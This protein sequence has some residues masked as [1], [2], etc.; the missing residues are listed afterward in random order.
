M[1]EIL[2]NRATVIMQIVSN[3]FGIQLEQLKTERKRLYVDARHLACRLMYE[4]CFRVEDVQLFLCNS[5][6]GVKHALKKCKNICQTEESY[7]Q[8]YLQAK[9]ILKT[10]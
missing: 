5:V 10:I 1:K 9:S 4:D 2:H 7:R 3:L 8:K 6:G